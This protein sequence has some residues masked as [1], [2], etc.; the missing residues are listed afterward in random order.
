M[1]DRETRATARATVSVPTPP[2]RA[3]ATFTDGPGTWWPPEFTWS[4]DV[5]AD[6]GIEPRA[7]G[8]CTEHGPH[9]FRIDW[10]R[11]LRWEPPRRLVL[12]WQISP[13]RVPEPDPAKASQ[14][15]VTFVDQGPAGTEVR[16]VHSC[17]DRHGEGGDGYRAAMA[18]QGWPYILERYAAAVR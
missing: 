13:E 6:I 7:G 14:I 17:F 1:T 4:R 18:E 16:L 2:D 11:V 5:L 3:F 15:E 8:L 9:G 10:G 12:S